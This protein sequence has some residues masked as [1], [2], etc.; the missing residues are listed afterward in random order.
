MAPTSFRWAAPRS[1][2]P[3]FPRAHRPPRLGHRNVRRQLEF[4]SPVP[5]RSLLPHHP[6]ATP[7]PQ[8]VRPAPP[9]P[10]AQED[11][12]ETL[13]DIR[14]DLGDCTR[15]GLSA[16]RTQIVFG[17]GNPDADLVIVGEG[18]GYHED[19]TG[20]P[21]VGRA[22]QLLNRML[23][24]IDLQRRDVY[25]CNVVKCRPPNNR[26]PEPPEVAAC[27]PFMHRQLQSI[28]PRAILTVGS[29]ASRTVLGV[30]SSVG[31]LRREVH[32]V[33]SIPVVATY[34]PAYLLRTPRMKRTVWEDLLR[35]RALL[36][37]EETPEP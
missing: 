17:V 30:D 35:V 23:Q 33:L 27:S 5:H 26:D 2:R 20:E 19:R 15:C 28:Q 4:R 10:A 34:H 21:F 18:P 32:S 24:A 8:A 16:D 14:T 9:R 11:G 25:I 6:P 31:K 7:P 22:G 1:S 29:F 36:R 12:R 37:N 13:D 3:P